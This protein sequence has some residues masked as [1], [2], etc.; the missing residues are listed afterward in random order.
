MTEELLGSALINKADLI[1]N[2]EVILPTI[3]KITS[4][5]YVLDSMRQL[6][7]DCFKKYL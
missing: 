4:L 5:S 1:K 7:N 6:L 3:T 2:L